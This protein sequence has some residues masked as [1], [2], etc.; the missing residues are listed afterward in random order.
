MEDLLVGGIRLKKLT[1]IP[2]L[3]VKQHW[4]YCSTTLGFIRVSCPCTRMAVT[5]MQPGVK[6]MVIGA[7]SRLVPKIFPPTM[8]G[9]G[10]E[11]YDTSAALASLQLS[12]CLDTLMTEMK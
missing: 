11:F 9:G 7:M 3:L 8:N 10:I 1:C 4:L 12:Y 5:I 6:S 2:M